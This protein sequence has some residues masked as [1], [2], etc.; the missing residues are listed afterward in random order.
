MHRRR[1]LFFISFIFLVQVSIAQVNDT[2]PLANDTTRLEHITKPNVD[3]SLRIQNL[4]PYFSMHV[5]SSI[6]YK[7]LINKTPSNYYWYLKNA[8]AGLTVDKDHGIIRVKSN[9]SLFLSGRVKYDY[10]YTVQIGVQSLIDPKDKVDTSFIIT[11]YN[12]DVILP[13]IKPSVLSPIYV[14]EGNTINFN[15]LCENGNFPITGIL[16]SSSASISNFKMPKKCDDVF[17]WTP[18]Y[19]FANDKDS[20]KVKIVTLN[21]V[22]TTQFNFNDTARIKVIVKDGLNFD[23][24]NQEYDSLL[25]G[26]KGINRW[27][28]DLKYT[29]FQLDKRIR[30]TKNTRSTFDIASAT[31]TVSGTI[32]STT[33]KNNNAGKIIPSAGVLII[34]IKE[35][36]APTKTVEQNQANLV[37]STIKRLEYVAFDNQISSKKDPQILA[38]I[39]TLKKELRQ[40]QVQLAEVPTEGA[41][42]KSDAELDKYFNSPK[43][44]KKY[45]TKQ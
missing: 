30:K 20:G 40:S 29:F 10:D 45:R 22:G 26:K 15:I 27:I 37:R 39:E 32:I 23:L 44:Q 6:N 43:V 13:R 11:F 8:P 42:N 1:I 19:D 18:P 24:A 12:T 38:K 41:S 5:D 31:S 33:D 7:L 16:F 21:F 9:K 3:T 17:E 35:A 25:N 36:A 28:K 14:D 2:I 4:N 34:P